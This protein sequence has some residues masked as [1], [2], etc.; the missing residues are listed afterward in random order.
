MDRITL[1]YEV[2][3]K[4]NEANRLEE[5]STVLP[6]VDLIADKGQGRGTETS[7]GS[8]KLFTRGIKI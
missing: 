6:K 8:D 3:L 4:L 5:I 2:L 7:R 1:K